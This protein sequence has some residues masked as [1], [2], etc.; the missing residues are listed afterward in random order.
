MTLREVLQP[1]AVDLIACP[2]LLCGYV[3]QCFGF[4]GFRPATTKAMA[5]NL[6]QARTRAFPSI[7]ILTREFGF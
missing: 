1:W 6:E 5:F 7:R 2:E 3:P 4:F